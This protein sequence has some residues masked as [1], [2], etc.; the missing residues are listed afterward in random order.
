MVVSAGPIPGAVLPQG[1]EGVVILVAA[2]S[3]VVAAVAAVGAAYFARRVHGEFADTV[4]ANLVEDVDEVEGSSTQ[5]EAL[6][7]GVNELAAAERRAE[8]ELETVG[9]RLAAV[10][11]MAESVDDVERV[12]AKQFPEQFERFSDGQAEL[13]S[14]MDTLADQQ[15]QGFSELRSEYTAIEEQLSELDAIRTELDRLETFETE[16]KRLKLIHSEMGRLEAIEDEL[17]A[18]DGID[19]RLAAVE[20]ALSTLE[21]VEEDVAALRDARE[22][23]EGIGAELAVIEDQLSELDGTSVR[24]TRTDRNDGTDGSGGSDGSDRSETTFDNVSTDTGTEF[25]TDDEEID[26]DIKYRGSDDED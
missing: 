3:A 26:L 19:D 15:K 11:A 2:A 24:R 9:Q 4:P 1:V 18:L 23:L 10:D 8:S 21:A 25:D 20:S 6:I 13:R 5:L 12:I 7:R 22:E 14:A 16:L 17:S